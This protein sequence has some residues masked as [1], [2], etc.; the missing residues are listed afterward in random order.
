MGGGNRGPGGGKRAL[1]LVGKGKPGGIITRGNGEITGGKG[2]TKLNTARAGVE[3]VTSLPR[4]GAETGVEAATTFLGGNG[5]PGT[6]GTV[7]IHGGGLRG[8]GDRLA[9]RGGRDGERTRDEKRM[10]RRGWGMRTRKS[11]GSLVLLHRDG[12]VM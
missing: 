9:E 5:T 2:T 8:V 6:A 12:L 4:V 3:S 1:G 10:R 7:Q 11:G